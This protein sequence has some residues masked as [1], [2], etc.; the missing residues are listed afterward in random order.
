[1]DVG[2]A[3]SGY[4]VIGRV[5][6]P[7]AVLRARRVADGREVALRPVPDEAL[8]RVRA[9]VPGLLVLDDP[10]VVAVHE[11]V[12]QPGAAFLVLDWVDGATLVEVRS[13]GARLLVGQRLGVVRGLL[14]G[15][16][17]AHDQGVV[18]GRIQLSNILLDAEGVARPVDFGLGDPV[19]SYRAPE[20][21]GTDDLGTPASDV[22]AVAAVLVHLLTDRTVG[23]QSRELLAVDSSLRGVLVT[24]LAPV[25]AERHADARAL[26]DALDAAARR[27]YGKAWWTEA[28]VGA[29]VAP[30]VADVVPLAAAPAPVAPAGDRPGGKL[31]RR[32][33]PR[34]SL[35]VPRGVIAAVLGLLTV[36]AV[37]GGAVALRVLNEDIPPD[38][39]SLRT[40]MFCDV[41]TDG[42]EAA[43]GPDAQ[44]R[45]TSSGS[46]GASLGPSARASVS[47]FWGVASPSRVVTITVGSAAERDATSPE[48]L[49]G[50][51]DG[52]TQDY[53]TAQGAT[54][55][56]D[57]ATECEELDELDYDAAF[58]CFAP[59]IQLPGKPVRAGT[60]VIQHAVAVR[61]QALVCGGSLAVEAAGDRASYDAL[62]E[63]LGSLCAEVLPEVR[64]GG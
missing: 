39:V 38:P 49:A 32:E 30:A 27:A 15:L 33:R 26:L 41:F 40:D 19:P 14:T 21:E 36:G 22:Y 43:I 6:A 62:V 42:A 45:F 4:D 61:D 28:G 16:A 2:P 29:L 48:R 37:V 13:S 7:G 8:D 58:A 24:A 44:P 10:H 54:F 52:A 12:D 57:H 18:H 59:S 64:R 1:M 46:S 3:V 60:G 55:T 20:L 35:R 5:D 17:A 63:A 31:P 50:I 9:I 47:C 56:A 51:L 23:E 53:L 34:R 11:L 25:P